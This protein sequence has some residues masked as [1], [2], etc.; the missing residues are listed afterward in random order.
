MAQKKKVIK[1]L[2][3]GG[4]GFIGTHLCEEL[5]SRG[6]K[7]TVVDDFSTAPGSHVQFLAGLKTVRLHKG[8]VRD[9][10]LMARLIRKCDVVY[11]LAAAV[12]V[13]L[14]LEHPVDSILTNIE[15]TAN[16]L[17]WAARYHKRVVIASS[18]EVYGKGTRASMNEKDDRVLGPT[19]VSRW[20]YSEA[21]AIDEFL[22]LAYF[23]E[24]KLPV[25]ICRLFN[26]VGPRQL[27][28]YG[29]VL[30]RFIQA[31]LAGKPIPV[32]GDGSQ[33]RS[34]TY[35]KDAVRAI[36]DLSLEKKAEGEIFNV[37]NGQPVTIKALAWKVKKATRSVSRIDYIPYKK[38]YR[39]RAVD[40]EDI[41]CRIPDISKIKK[42]LGY[43]PQY[44]L[45]KIVQETINYAKEGKSP[46]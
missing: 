16:V 34:F 26:T 17:K 39:G 3:T 40:F 21:K 22:A 30:P 35:V 15:G 28:R 31:A 9:P 45:I 24:K 5:L 10:Q 2:I 1:A 36:V 12:G 14:I 38:A 7:I 23:K 33:I 6:F 32:Y 41:R 25:V 46:K 29:M 37:G 27:G 4:A 42:L 13:K 20:S 19:S 8:S 44:N 11:H 18:S 43:R